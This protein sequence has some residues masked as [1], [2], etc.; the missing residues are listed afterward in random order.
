MTDIKQNELLPGVLQWSI[1]D[2]KVTVLVDSHFNAGEEFFTKLPEGGVGETLKKAFR[3]ESLILTT[4]S[5][6]IESDEHEPVLIDTGMGTKMAPH[7]TGR[8]IEALAFIG[9]KPEDIGIPPIYQ[10]PGL[11]AIRS[12]FLLRIH[13]GWNQQ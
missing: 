3:S 5:F 6:L 2:R 8:L 12:G 10:R 4:S 1:G 9:K 7:L 13:K 11:A